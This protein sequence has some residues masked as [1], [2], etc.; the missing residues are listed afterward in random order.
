MNLLAE[1]GLYNNYY[2]IQSRPEL[3][4]QGFYL[5]EC[6]HFSHLVKDT[7]NQG[8]NQITSE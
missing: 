6:Y 7:L 2:K 5:D 1:N 4:E 3:G 8:H